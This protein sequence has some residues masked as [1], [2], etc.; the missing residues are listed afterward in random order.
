MRSVIV[1]IFAAILCTIFSGAIRAENRIALVV[2]NSSYKNSPLRNPRND[3]TLMADTLEDVGFEVTRVFDA[4]QRTMK[5]AMI[6]FGRKLRRSDSVGLF[7]YAGHGVQLEGEN[8]LIPIGA[9]IGDELEIGVEAVSVNEFLRTMKRASSRINIVVLDACRNNPFARSFRSSTRGLAA[10]DAPKGTY[11]AYATSPGAIALDGNS[12]HSPYTTALAR[13]IVKPGLVIEQVFKQARRAVLKLTDE[14]QTPWETSSIT[15]RFYFKPPVA[16]AAVTPKPE[17]QVNRSSTPSNNSH[18]LELAYWDTIKSTRNPALFKSYLRQFPSGAFVDLANV[19]IHQLEREKAGDD[20]NSQQSR[21]VDAVTNSQ[22]ESLYW[23][24]VKDTDDPILLNAYLEKF[25]NGIFAGLATVMIARLKARVPPPP[26]KK[27]EPQAVVA[28]PEIEPEIEQPVD[29]APQA[30]PK[31]I[32]V[33]ALEPTQNET[34]AIVEEPQDPDLPRKIQTALENAGCNPGK[35]DGFW[36]RKSSS[37]LSLFARHA[38]VAI[39]EEEIS[40]DTLSLFAGR[41]GRICPL[42]CGRGYTVENDNCVANKPVRNRK[43]RTTNTQQ[44]TKR[45]KKIVCHSYGCGEDVTSST[46]TNKRPVV[47]RKASPTRRKASKPSSK[48]GAHDLNGPP[49]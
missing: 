32:V 40:A 16:Q 41:V 5:R 45:T 2:G 38:N 21:S 20:T 4:D 22:Q 39:P 49:W 23:N 19:M 47:T 10:V 9:D 46:S 33:V 43:V 30:S 42:I 8:Y 31:K 36:G 37:A 28:V 18:A 12:G 14:Q 15:G 44:P 11:V 27:V 34:E 6:K 24:T 13:A 7:Y 29:P 26:K 1:A 35:V 17:Q 25:P 48:V 3:A